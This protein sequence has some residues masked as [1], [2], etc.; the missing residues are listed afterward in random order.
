MGYYDN[1]M[2]GYFDRLFGIRP[3]YYLIVKPYIVITD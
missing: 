3:I 2:S 1:L